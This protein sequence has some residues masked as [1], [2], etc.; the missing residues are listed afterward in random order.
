MR[1]SPLVLVL[2]IS[3]SYDFEQGLITLGDRAHLIDETQWRDIPNCR[4]FH[5]APA[6]SLL[7]WHLNHRSRH[8]Q[9]PRGSITEVGTVSVRKVN[10]SE[11]P[12]SWVCRLP[13]LADAVQCISIS[14][15]TWK[16][17]HTLRTYTPRT[18]TSRTKA[19]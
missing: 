14:S 4:H 18:N 11:R 7:A 9:R 10:D 3:L 19:L 13:R 17:T 2:V 15:D 6:L 16:G 1:T 12:W 5:H 8:S